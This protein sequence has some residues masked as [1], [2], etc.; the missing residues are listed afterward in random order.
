VNELSH[1]PMPA[2]IFSR[3]RIRCAA[4]TAFSTLS[5]RVG[6]AQDDLGSAQRLDPALAIDLVDRHL[7]AHLLELA[8]ARPATGERRHQ[9][10]LHVLGGGCGGRP[11]ER[12]SQQQGESER[13]NAADKP[14]SK[15]PPSLE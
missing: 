14:S 2:L 11:D 13:E 7:R 6:L 1:E 10:D 15:G 12:Q 9:R 8:L 4:L 5:P 3:V